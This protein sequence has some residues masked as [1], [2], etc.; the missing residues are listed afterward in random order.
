MH[1]LLHEQRVEW[2]SAFMPIKDGSLIWFAPL[3]AEMVQAKDSTSQVLMLKGTA[4]D[5][6]TNRNGWSIDESELDGI[7]KQLTGSV[8]TVDHGT[9]VRDA[10]G[11]VT[12]AWREGNHVD[13]EAQVTTSDKSITEPIMTGLVDSVSIQIPPKGYKIARDSKNKDMKLAAINGARISIVLDPAYSGT[14]FDTVGFCASVNKLISDSQIE[15][16]AE[17][18][19]EN[20]KEGTTMAD[21]PKIE[22]KKPEVPP[23][24][25][26]QAQAAQPDFKA[27]YDAMKTEMDAMKKEIIE[28]RSKGVQASTE[29]ETKPETEG[30]PVGKLGLMATAEFYAFAQSKNDPN[31]IQAISNSPELKAAVDEAQRICASMN[32]GVK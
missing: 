12:R 1:S 3:K 27:S 14:K 20:D 25:P 5:D 10:V 17:G 23:P 30:I 7:A 19:T 21:E 31:A 24:A 16:A 22:E 11:K 15:V 26:M 32:K 6:S 9:S 18:G 2:R 28:L 29:P 8:L 4:V 13:Y